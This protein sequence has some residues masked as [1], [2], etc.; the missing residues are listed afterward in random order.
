MGKA[1]FSCVNIPHMGFPSALESV[2][3]SLDNFGSHCITWETEVG[4]GMTYNC[5]EY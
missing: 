2:C 1:P 4:S 5:M 3:P